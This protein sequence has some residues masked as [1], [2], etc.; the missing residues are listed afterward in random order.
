MNPKVAKVGGLKSQ[1][2]KGEIV[3][4]YLDPFDNTGSEVLRLS[5]RVN[6]MAKSTPSFKFTIV[7]GRS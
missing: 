7:L 5:C 3:V 6:K 4:G 1:G 2:V